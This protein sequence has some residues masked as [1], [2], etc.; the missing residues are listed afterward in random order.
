MLVKP[1]PTL[2]PPVTT[3]YGSRGTKPFL[4]E[5]NSTRRKE[6]ISNYIFSDNNKVSYSS[7][8]SAINF[9]ACTKLTPK[10]TSYPGSMKKEE[11]DGENL[12]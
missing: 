3:K 6:T 10:L 1:H 4:V 8:G 12:Y 5:N 7:T 11:I 2:L 9:L